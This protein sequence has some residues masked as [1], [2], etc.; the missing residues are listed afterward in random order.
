MC[1][2]I[3]DILATICANCACQEEAHVNSLTLMQ[4]PSFHDNRSAIQKRNV[5]LA[6]TEARRRR[7]ISRT[8][9]QNV[10]LRDP[11]KGDDEFSLRRSANAPKKLDGVN[12]SW[13]SR[14]CRRKLQECRLWFLRDLQ[15]D[16]GSR[17]H[18][19]SSRGDARSLQIQST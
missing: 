16:A 9:Q 12:Y 18:D 8:R 2:F 1:E 15:Q 4:S 17:T 3:V 10:A 5:D 6:P 11:A 13:C 7:V 14:W 19:G